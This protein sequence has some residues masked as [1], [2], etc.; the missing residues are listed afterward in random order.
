MKFVV[1]IVTYWFLEHL[2]YFGMP[3]YSDAVKLVKI[4]LQCCLNLDFSEPWSR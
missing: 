3:F 4:I 2:K 1:F